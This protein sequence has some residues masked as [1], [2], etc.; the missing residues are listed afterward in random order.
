MEILAIEREGKRED[1]QWI[2][3]LVPIRLVSLNRNVCGLRH[4]CPRAVHSNEEFPLQETI[5]LDAWGIDSPM[6]YLNYQ[7]RSRHQGII[8]DELVTWTCT[9]CSG[10]ST[11]SLPWGSAI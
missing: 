6:D 7:K 5:F 9:G 2:E 1:L 10:S 4:R 8:K 11:G 3:V